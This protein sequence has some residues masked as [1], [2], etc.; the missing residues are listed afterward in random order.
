MSDVSNYGNASANFLKFYLWLLLFEI[1][2]L[3]YLVVTGDAVFLY[4]FIAIKIVAVGYFC[5]I[6]NESMVSVGK[7]HGWP[8]GLL[9]IIPFGFWA[10]YL[11]VRRQLALSGKWKGNSVFTVSVVLANLIFAVLVVVFIVVVLGG[12]RNYAQDARRISDMRQIA[13]MQEIYRSENGAYF[14]CS[15]SNGD[16]GG[17]P[18]NY[19]QT[20]GNLA[21]PRD[22]ANGG[23][24]CVLE[25]TY[26]G[27]DNTASLGKDFCYYA[28]LADGKEKNFYIAS[29]AGDY[30][31]HQPPSDMQDCLSREI[32]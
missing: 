8:L 11:I 4:A 10:A 5:M 32:R 25:F 31:K 13:K 6:I 14:T 19:P 29:S 1:V 28:K 9:V 7:K 20:I 17:Q 24:L 30:L 12:V 26:C 22:P 3:G 16:C 18:N 15:E 2:I 21:T 23:D 27:L